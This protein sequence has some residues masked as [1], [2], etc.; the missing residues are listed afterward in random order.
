MF[1]RGL[2]G[3]RLILN[4]FHFVFK[5]VIQFVK[6]V[7][8]VNTSFVSLLVMSDVVSSRL[9]RFGTPKEVR[10]KKAQ[11]LGFPKDETD[12]TAWILLEQSDGTQ[13]VTWQVTTDWQMHQVAC[14]IEVMLPMRFTS[15]WCKTLTSWLNI[16]AS[17]SL[18]KEFKWGI[19]V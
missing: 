10:R 16:T 7:K 6:R 11:S 5:I 4:Q 3:S 13:P 12:I 18:D 17:C 9:S 19:Q 2:K 15:T 14:H 1:P 8:A